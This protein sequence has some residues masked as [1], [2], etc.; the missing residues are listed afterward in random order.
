MKKLIF[1][2]ISLSF[3]ACSERE[4]EIFDARFEKL[5]NHTFSSACDDYKRTLSEWNRK[6]CINEQLDIE[7]LDRIIEGR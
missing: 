3:I 6:R 2:L 4:K 1:I 5:N 7:R